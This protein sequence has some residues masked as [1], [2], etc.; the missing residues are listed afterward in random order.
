MRPKTPMMQ[1]YFQ[2]K[3][4]HPDTLMAMRVGDFYEFYGEDAEVAARALE[5]TLTGRED[6]EVGRIPMAGVPFHSVEKYLARLV[7]NGFKVA[8]CDQLEDPKK[9]KGL[10]KRGVTR[11]LSAGTILEDTMLSPSSNNFLASF[12]IEGER[13][14][15]SMLDPSTGEFLATEIR[16]NPIADRILQEIA[17]VRP[18]ELLYEPESSDVSQMAH[19]GLEVP[20]TAVQGISTERAE[21]LLLQHFKV[22]QLAGFGLDQSPMAVRAAAMI[23]EYAKKNG[24]T[25]GHVDSISTF[26]ID[27]FMRL[28]PA[29][30][31]SLELTQSMMDGTKR[32]TLLEV[33]DHCITPMG[34]RC[35]KKWVE[36]P[37]LDREQIEDRNDAVGRL[38][39]HSLAR[40]DIRD[41]LK[42]V[43]DIERL[44]S[45]CCTGLASPRDMAGLKRSL[46]ALPHVD[47]PLQKVALKL[48]FEIR[49][50]LGNHSQLA[51][52]LHEAIVE[53]PPLTVREG[54]IFKAGFDLELDKLRDLSRNG[55][56]Y[57][58][59]LES[60]ERQK[61]GI[62]KLK[63]GYNSVF[64]YYLEVGKSHIEK[65]PDHYIRKQTTALAERYITAEL[66]DHESAVLGAEE[67]AQLLEAD[68]FSR[69]R[70]LIAENASTLLKAARALA[71]LDTFCS[72]AE[73]ASL[74]QYV[75]PE[76]CDT[77]CLEIVA[78]RHPV[79]EIRHSFV[80]NDLMLNELKKTIVLTGPNM[81]GKSTFLR[82]TALVV[83][84]AQIG[85]YVP[86][87]SCKLSISDRIFTRV[88]ARDELAQGQSTFMVEMVESAN[89]LNNATEQSLVVLD[90]VGRGT[91]TFDGLAIAWAM[92]EHLADVRA[93]TLFA[94]HY[95]Q[96]NEISEQN[97]TVAN[98]RV[99]VEEIGDQVV[100][101]HKVLPGGTDKSYGIQ[102]AKLA[103]VP[104]SVVGRA[105][106]VLAMLE[107]D[108]DSTITI[109]PPIER[110]QLALFEA[111]DS[112][113]VQ[114]LNKIDV[115][116]LTPIEA[117]MKLDEWQKR[118]SKKSK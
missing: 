64:G 50:N 47:E 59:D 32:N 94:T 117:L 86:A 60:R 95:H 15:L 7:Q 102:V 99:A 20:I 81:S 82:Q 36:Q 44:V 34:S 92:V 21:V 2:A 22:N 52:K 84:M 109:R 8:L 89:I 14:G 77:E 115:S 6:S 90:E 24:L 10:V 51:M 23:I 106:E 85:S 93:K 53:D 118:F 57:I 83:L 65:V 75:K 38:K 70:N 112:A 28:D 33:L 61:T 37:L 1:Q 55:K 71:E 49:R 111:E 114:E 30:R 56:S 107:G 78:G 96:L 11:V 26:S 4:L 63:V 40:G 58:A 27:Q 54:G 3:S 79:V 42:Q 110:L 88:G 18:A 69:M 80:P 101:T 25:L 41:A 5:I 105:R 45:R 39:D 108:G 91:S 12:V 73:S 62:D 104:E 76:F 16:E 103:G 87:T 29:T 31:R 17:R 43:A 72:L 100:W 67:R 13:A 113:V 74:N 68:L 97:P 116:R 9:A 19:D 66:K 35:L 46:F 98:F 48:L